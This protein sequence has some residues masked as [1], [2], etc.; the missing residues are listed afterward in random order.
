MLML[1]GIVFMPKEPGLINMKIML[2]RAVTML[3]LTKM[4]LI[5]REIL[6]L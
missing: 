6:L 1:I 5:L 3:I 2:M 4:V